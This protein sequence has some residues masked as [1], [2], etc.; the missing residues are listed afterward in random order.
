MNNREE[1]ERRGLSVEGFKNAELELGMA[2][3][4]EMRRHGFKGKITTVTV[5]YV[6]LFETHTSFDSMIGVP[7][8]DKPVD[9][10]FGDQNIAPGQLFIYSVKDIKIKF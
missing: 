3:S 2:S 4:R 8:D 9:P 5:T 7:P 10:G 1:T 6:A